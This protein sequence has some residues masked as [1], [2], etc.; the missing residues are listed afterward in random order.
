VDDQ[1][2]GVHSRQKAQVIVF[3][4]VFRPSLG[5]P[6]A[7]IQSVLGLPSSGIK[8]PKSEAGNMLAFSAE[9]TEL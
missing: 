6:Q 5:P 1:R 4:T 3:S 9:V 8:R 7:P 2:I